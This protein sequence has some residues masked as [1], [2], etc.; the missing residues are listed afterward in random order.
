V[1]HLNEALHTR[2]VIGQA[3]GILIERYHLDEQ[4]AFA[5][6]T[7]VSSHSNTKIRVIASRLVADTVGGRTQEEPLP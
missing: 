4:A 3:V 1:H 6:L 7:R 2:Q 5:F